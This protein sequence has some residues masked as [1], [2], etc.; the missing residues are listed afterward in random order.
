MTNFGRYPKVNE[1][2]GIHFQGIHGGFMKMTWN[3]FK[4]KSVG[5]FFVICLNGI[6]FLFYVD[7][8]GGVPIGVPWPMAGLM[9][10][11]FSTYAFNTASIFHALHLHIGFN[12]QGMLAQ[13]P[14]KSVAKNDAVFR[15]NS[16]LEDD[17]ESDGDFID[18]MIE[19]NDDFINAPGLKH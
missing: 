14:A 2:Q 6:Y 7:A 18:Q 10:A 8:N 15:D 19:A 11:I 5:H 3:L 17:F 12:L 9:C 1:N 13:E 16:D 4:K